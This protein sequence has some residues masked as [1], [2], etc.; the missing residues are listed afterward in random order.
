MELRVFAENQMVT[1]EVATKSVNNTNN[2]AVFQVEQN[3]ADQKAK[4]KKKAEEE[5][6][7]KILE[8]LNLEDNFLKPSIVSYK[9]RFCL[10]LTRPANDKLRGDQRGDFQMG[11]IKSKLGVKDG[12]ISDF[13]DMEDITGRPNLAHSDGATIEAGKSL[14]IP[15]GELG[16]DYPFY[17]FWNNDLSEYVQKYLKA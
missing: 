12:V 5:L 6:K 7:N 11:A 14:L 2:E 8:L 17:R 15:L 3:K 9:Q 4:A 1:T 10:K 16:K 13:N